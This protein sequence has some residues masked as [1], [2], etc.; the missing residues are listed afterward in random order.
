[1]QINALKARVGVTMANQA[2]AAVPFKT[3]I[4]PILSTIDENDLQI[5]QT[6]YLTLL[7]SNPAKNAMDILLILYSNLISG[8]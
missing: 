3:V 1:M 2:A 5:L 8:D 4:E 6:T 7:D